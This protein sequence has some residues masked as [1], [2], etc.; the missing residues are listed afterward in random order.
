[1]QNK[2]DLMDHPTKSAKHDESIAD[3][4]IFGLLVLFLF[5]G[6]ILIG[7]W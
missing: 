2:E 1:M 3:I 6:F 7:L 5:T 4:L